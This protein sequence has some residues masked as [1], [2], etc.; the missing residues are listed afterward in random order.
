M[1]YRKVI[2]IDN[3]E[4]RFNGIFIFIQLQPVINYLTQVVIFKIIH[5][6]GKAFF[7]ML[8]DYMLNNKPTLT[9]TWA[10]NQWTLLNTAVNP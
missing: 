5:K 8:F 2:K 6:H 7:N 10:A 3:I 1:R 9:G 4:G